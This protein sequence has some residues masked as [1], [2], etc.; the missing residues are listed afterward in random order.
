VLLAGEH[1]DADVTRRLDLAAGTGGGIGLLLHG[2]G[3]DEGPSLAATRWRVAGRAGGSPHDLG[4]PQWR[5]E[6]LRGRGRSRSWPVTWR[7]GLES[8][9]ID[10]EPRE[11][12][13][14]RRTR[15]P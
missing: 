15:R 7:S 4:D 11:E 2:E 6:L 5:L 10:D 3:E 13:E 14:P 9:V 12:E 8:L 1:P